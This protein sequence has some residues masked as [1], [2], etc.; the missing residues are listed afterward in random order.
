MYY[1]STGSPH[2]VKPRGQH[3]IDRAASS[4]DITSVPRALLFQSLEHLLYSFLRSQII[5]VLFLTTASGEVNDGQEV[6]EQMVTEG[7]VK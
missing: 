1:P 5:S 2:W 4:T 7:K 6:W 3:V